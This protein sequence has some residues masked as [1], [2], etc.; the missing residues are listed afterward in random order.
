MVHDIVPNTRSTT[1][2]TVKTLSLVLNKF[3]VC[4]GFTK[5]TQQLQF[6]ANFVLSVL[7]IFQIGQQIT[8][9]T[10]ILLRLVVLYGMTN[11]QFFRDCQYSCGLI[12]QNFAHNPKKS[13][14]LDLPCTIV[15]P[16]EIGIPHTTVCEVHN[17]QIPIISFIIRYIQNV[18][19]R[20]GIKIVS[21]LISKH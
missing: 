14:Y 7:R 17:Q 21:L 6:N 9:G 19:K 3:M 11:H 2:V 10:N 1:T 15:I 5:L 13:M 16:R 18:K 4:F 12:R 8:L 20:K